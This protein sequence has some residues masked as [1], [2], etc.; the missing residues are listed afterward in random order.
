MTGRA[1]PNLSTHQ[2]AH[3]VADICGML[4]G[5]LI[6]WFS[7]DLKTEGCWMLSDYHISW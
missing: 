1:R 7:D 2:P 4:P 3:L 6:S 5:N